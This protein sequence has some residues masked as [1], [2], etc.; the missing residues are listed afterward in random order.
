MTDHTIR[1]YGYNPYVPAPLNIATGK[2]IWFHQFG[3]VANSKD[4]ETAVS[5]YFT[6]FARSLY[7][8][9]SETSVTNVNSLDYAMSD[10]EPSFQ[11]RGGEI[12]TPETYHQQLYM[13][14]NTSVLGVIYGMSDNNYNIDFGFTSKFV[15]KDAR[16]V[17]VLRNRVKVIFNTLVRNN[18]L[19]DIIL[20]VDDLLNDA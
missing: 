1:Y 6:L 4:K 18:G 17:S 3:D 5:G 19:A 2:E 13:V 7:I 11:I 9:N 15:S 16:E 10:N 20:G 12:I 8:H 14:D